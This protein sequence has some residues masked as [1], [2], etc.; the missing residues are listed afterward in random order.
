MRLR[1]CIFLLLGLGGMSALANPPASVKTSPSLS[2]LASPNDDTERFPRIAHDQRRMVIGP[3]TA[4]AGNCVCGM[5]CNGDKCDSNNAFP[6]DGCQTTN[7]RPA[8]CRT[9]FRDSVSG[10]LCGE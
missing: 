10:R 9:C 2:G 8:G 4:L 3:I 7:G 1:L 6:S 5:W